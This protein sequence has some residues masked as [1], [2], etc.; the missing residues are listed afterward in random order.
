MIEKKPILVTGI[1]RSGT[2]W[3]G[4]ALATC[5]HTLYIHELTNPASPWNSCFPTP[6]SYYQINDTNGGAFVYLLDRLANLNPVFYGDWRKDI[7]KDRQKYI[8]N[9]TQPDVTPRLILK[10]PTALFSANWFTEKN[11][12][13]VVIV[14]RHPISIIKS[15]LKLGWS[16]NYNSNFIRKQPGL[17]N[18][19]YNGISRTDHKIIDST[20][21]VLKT[22]YFVRLLYLAI[23]KYYLTQGKFIFI[24][25]EKYM[26][27]PS[28]HFPVLFKKLNLNPT[29]VSNNT[30]NSTQFYDINKK[31]QNTGVP[32][33]TPDNNLYSNEY[34]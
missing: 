19:L 6:T 27:S 33:K 28:D 11:N 2:T 16:V 4:R 10:D 14:L 18:G 13:K 21:N 5:E 9:N 32:I 15:I 25:Y 26:Q 8:V 1:I 24:S 12:A 20:S 29:E 23:C 34:G 30:L 17:L 7:A 31:H 3:V 22:T